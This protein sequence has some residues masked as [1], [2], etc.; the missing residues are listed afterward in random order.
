[1]RKAVAAASLCQA[2]QAT[3]RKPLCL[4]RKQHT[5]T[6]ISERFQ[7]TQQEAGVQPVPSTHLASTRPAAR[8]AAD[9]TAHP[10]ALQVRN[11][12]TGPGSSSSSNSQKHPET[13]TASY[14]HAYSLQDIR[15][16]IQ[17]ALHVGRQKSTCT[18]EACGHSLLQAAPSTQ[19]ART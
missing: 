16:N 7:P 18:T 1:V 12:L 19:P 9:R 2:V 11:P 3:Q 8:S 14:R 4:V 17:P 13:H 5:S 15:R 6:S 10:V